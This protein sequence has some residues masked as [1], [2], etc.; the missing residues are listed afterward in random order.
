MIRVA[1]PLVLL[2]GSY[3]FGYNQG[4]KNPKLPKLTQEAKAPSQI[5]GYRIMDFNNNNYR[6]HQFNSD[7]LKAFIKATKI[8]NVVRLNAQG[9][10]SVQEE[11][12]ICQENGVAFYYIPVV[13][14]R[15]MVKAY[16]NIEPIL[17]S[18]H[19]LVHCEDGMLFTNTITARY[20]ADLA[21]NMEKI[22]S[23]YGLDKIKQ[24]NRDFYNFVTQ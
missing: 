18:G 3:L 7:E 23:F 15:T 4:Q 6:S 21:M 22:K 9:V 11:E 2:V 14:L 17:D 16:K 8:K 5:E 19:T 10:L 13:D 12:Q 1:L 24:E 20:S